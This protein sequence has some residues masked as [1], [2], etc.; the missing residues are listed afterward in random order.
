MKKQVE[1][2]ILLF[3]GLAFLV[4]L[5]PFIFVEAAKLQSGVTI[6]APS[7][8]GPCQDD[9]R[10]GIDDITGARCYLLPCPDKDGDRVNDFTGDD[11]PSRSGP[12]AGTCA[13]QLVSGVPI[14]YGQ[15]N[16]GQDS[17]EQKVTLKN[18]GTSQTPAKIMVKGGN[19]VSDAAG[20]P[21]ISGPEITHVAIAPNLDWGNKKA[22]SSNGWELGQISGGQSIPVYFQFKVP[23][24]GVSGSLHQD[25]TIDLL[26]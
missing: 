17:A 3:F 11:C 9:D 5:F 10:D 16:L 26:C 13:L 2:I 20:N 25:V 15:L 14:N 23:L 18:G 7:S 19:W 1:I 22:L 8:A 24:S 21:T 6:N 12:V 4:Y